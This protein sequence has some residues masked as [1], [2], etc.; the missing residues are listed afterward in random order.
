[1][2][3]IILSIIVNVF[4]VEMIFAGGLRLGMTGAVKQKVKELDKKVVEYKEAKSTKYTITGKLPMSTGSIIR[5]QSISKV[6]AFY[7]KW[8]SVAEIS[9]GSFS[10]DVQTGVPVGLI[11]VDNNNKYS[12]YLSLK[13]GIESIPLT[14]ISSGT[15][16]IDLQTLSIS[17]N[18]IEPGHNPIGDE[19]PLNSAEQ[20]ALAQCNGMFAS[21]VKNP[22]VDGNGVVDILE[23]KFYR[24]VIAY[25]VNA[26]NFSG[27][28]TPTLNNTVTMQFYNITL[29][30]GSDSDAGGAKVTGPSG[31]N[32][33]NKDCYVSNIGYNIYP[34]LGS[35]PTSIPTAGE[36]TFSLQNGSGR[37]LTINIPDQSQANSK[38]IVAVPTVVLNGDGTINKL[39]W[40]YRIPNDSSSNITPTAFID[41]IMVQINGPGPGDRVYDS[42][43]M[44]NDTTEHTLT[45]Q[46]IVWTK[47]NNISMAYNDVYGNHYVVTFYK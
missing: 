22:D 3:K 5:T 32:I 26:G 16:T 23:G 25:G 21:V 17:G 6:I 20:Q 29:P 47:V 46:D 19:I 9:D 13:N 36:Y 43:M 38:I 28:L 31:S 7:N 4:T 14:K 8:Y 44:P 39:T 40:E 33:T 15:Y 27:A 1:M 2:K 37:V 12:G 45:K 30:Y 18:V 35:S 34:N 10:V 41:S 42:P 11:F 24:P